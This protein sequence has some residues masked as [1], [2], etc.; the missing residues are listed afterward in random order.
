M[1]KFG[2]SPSRFYVTFYI[3]KFLLNLYAP[4]KFLKNSLF[5]YSHASLTIAFL[6]TANIARL[7][8]FINDPTSDKV[9]QE[10]PLTL[11]RDQ[12]GWYMQASLPNPS[13]LSC[14]SFRGEMVFQEVCVLIS[15]ILPTL[16][17]FLL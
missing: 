5:S 3:M 16:S 11:L 12:I 8:P 14:R 10:L 4:N 13:I 9:S 1:A 17:T 15:N 2:E 6:V 7:I